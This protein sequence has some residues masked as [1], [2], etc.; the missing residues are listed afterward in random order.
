MNYI[1]L[2]TVLLFCLTAPVSAQEPADEPPDE[3]AGIVT[4][5][6]TDAELLDEDACTSRM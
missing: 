4:D 1:S 2:I 6:T 5:E 3:T